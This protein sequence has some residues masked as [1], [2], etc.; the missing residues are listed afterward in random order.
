MVFDHFK[1][2]DS[3]GAV[4]DL[5]KVEPRNDSTQ[6]FDTRWHG[7]IISMRKKP[8][9]EVLENLYFRQFMCE[10]IHIEGDVV[11][12]SVLCCTCSQT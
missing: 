5:L 10:T 3:D 11:P 4:W 12:S 6:S 9:D 8:D 1:I 7:T 2:S